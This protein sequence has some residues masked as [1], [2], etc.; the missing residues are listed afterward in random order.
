M[1][2]CVSV[3]VTMACMRLYATTPCAIRV[4]STGP[5]IL[6]SYTYQ[7]T[8]PNILVIRVKAQ[9]DESVMG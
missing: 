6:A 2:E 7:G 9:S 1:G 4:S 8:E 3:S 5:N